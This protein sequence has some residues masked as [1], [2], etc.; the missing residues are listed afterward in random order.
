MLPQV[1]ELQELIGDVTFLSHRA[2][3]RYSLFVKGASRGPDDFDMNDPN[4]RIIAHTV[5]KGMFANGDDSDGDGDNDGVFEDMDVDGDGVARRRSNSRLE[6]SGDNPMQ[7]P[8]QVPPNAVQVIRQLADMNLAATATSHWAGAGGSRF[9]SCQSN[10]ATV[11]ER[12]R[13]V[14]NVRVVL[15]G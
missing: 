5:F 12:Q 13:C 14:V 7:P 1:A 2:M 10:R 11:D 9:M 6:G 3:Q 15:V 8:P 4:D